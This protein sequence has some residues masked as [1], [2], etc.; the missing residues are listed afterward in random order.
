[1]EFQIL[2][3][4]Y[5][6]LLVEVAG[7]ATPPWFADLTIA[8]HAMLAVAATDGRDRLDPMLVDR[9]RREC[10]L[11]DLGQLF[12]AYRIPLDFRPQAM[13]PDCLKGLLKFL[14]VS[15]GHEPAT[16]MQDAQKVHFF[17]I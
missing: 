17:I 4:N 14:F 5:I 9:L 10:L 3:G 6:F 12:I 16:K 13:R 2:L 11:A 1:M 7:G 15:T 8:V